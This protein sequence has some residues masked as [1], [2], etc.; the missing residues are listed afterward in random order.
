MH[1]YTLTCLPMGRVR[2]MGTWARDKREAID[3]TKK[4]L[5]LDER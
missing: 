2:R 3:E 4:I 1:L 5:A